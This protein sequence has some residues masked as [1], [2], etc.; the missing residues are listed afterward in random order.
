MNALR[1]APDRRRFLA[2]S[3][4][5]LAMPG[6]ARATSQGTE[7]I[8][9][10]AFATTWA[11][12]APDGTGLERLR[13]GIDA[14]LDRIDRQMSPWRT[15]SEI[16]AVNVGPAGRQEVSPDMATVC[17]AALH[18]AEDSDGFFDPTVGPILARWGFGPI[19]GDAAGDWRDIAVRGDGIEKA[20]PGATVDP[21]GIAKGWA[22]DRMTSLVRLAGIDDALLD[23]GGELRGM[24]RHPTG[25]PWR[26]AVE[27]PQAPRAGVAAFALPDLAIATSGLSRQSV[28]VGGRLHGHIVDPHRRETAS[29]ALLSVS[30]LHEEAMLA[31]AWATA[32]YA[33]GAATGPQIARRHGLSALFVAETGG[34]LVPQTTGDAASHM[35]W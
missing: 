13:P 20:A 29:G 8:E 22:L 25:R 27:D 35:L 17:R 7:R 2:M 32:L 18:V 3:G 12:T 1:Q 21:C 4:A 24:G 16:T 10:R 28:R 14:L 6:L 34:D 33:A 5:A 31:D 9:G 11:I 15:D 19:S 26:V 23:L 30:V